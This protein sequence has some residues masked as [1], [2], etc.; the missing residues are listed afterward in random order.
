MSCSASTP[1]EN[2]FGLLNALRFRA[3][4]TEK[5]RFNYS[6]YFSITQEALLL[7]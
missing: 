7:A 4:N 6:N 2:M 1:Q 3:L 5:Y